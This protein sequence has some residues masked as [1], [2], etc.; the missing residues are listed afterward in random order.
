MVY[1]IVGKLKLSVA[2]RK[3]AC[4][5][6]CISIFN[7]CMSA[8]LNCCLKI[9]STRVHSIYFVNCKAVLITLNPCVGTDT[10]K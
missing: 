5:R 3:Q 6:P 10:C 4:L 7:K 2:I 9:I 8:F 1:K